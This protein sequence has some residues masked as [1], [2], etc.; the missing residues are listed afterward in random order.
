MLD[1]ATASHGGG[2]EHSVLAADFREEPYWW[3]EAPRPVLAPVDVPAA[4]DVAVI[5]AGVTGLNAALVLA[6]A[7]RTVAVFDAQ[8]AGWGASTR[9]AGFIGR[10]SLHAFTSLI[11]T[12]GLAAATAIY[13][14]LQAAFDTVI[15]VIA[16]ERI[17]SGF[18]IC[19]RFTLAT[20]PGHYAAL[21]REFAAQ[22]K[23]LGV[24]YE[25]VPR[26]QE[27]G[28]IAVSDRFF[29]GVVIPNLGCVHPGLYHLGLLD[30]VRSAGAAMIAETP[31]TAVS[32]E[33]PHRFIVRTGRGATAAR[34]VVV[35]TNGYSGPALPALR[36]RLVP[37]DGF[38]I[39]SE[40]LPPERL[41]AALPTNRNYAD[42]NHN[43]LFARRSPDGTRLLFGGLT[44]S[45]LAAGVRPVAARLH[46]ELGRM[47]PGLSDVAISYAWSGRCAGTFD[48]YPHVGERDGIH[49]AIGYNYSGL[50]M[51]TY[52]GRKVAHKVLGS[53]TRCSGRPRA[54]RCSTGGAF[55]RCRSTTAR[56]GSCRWCSP[57]TPGA[58]AGSHE[59]VSPTS[60]ASTNSV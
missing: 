32:G 46:G 44:G 35:A 25:M 49:F 45:N 33:G 55:R 19:G 17:E 43:A 18:R 9:N 16:A 10:T 31:V 7:G 23:H 5:G 42:S 28:E 24:A 41:A 21:A 26:G 50:P 12:A 3:A 8:A 59:G 1:G 37:F 20:S 27:Q 39:A 56:P 2:A 30:R 11:D 57:P 60:A 6:R 4:V 48:R 40:R 15:G 22:H 51:G 38:M 54:T 53:P 34:N 14:E 58:I 47:L 52:L 13:T 36:R 29:G